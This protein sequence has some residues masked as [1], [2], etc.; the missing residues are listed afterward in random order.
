MP[1]SCFGL[2]CTWRVASSMALIESLRLEKTSKI[3]KSNRQPITTMPAKPCPEVPHPH[4]FSSLPHRFEDSPFTC[5]LRSWPPSHR[6]PPAQSH[7]PGR[8]ASR[9]RWEHP[10]RGERR[11]ELASCRLRRDGL[12]LRL[13]ARRT[14]RQSPDKAGPQEELPLGHQRSWARCHPALQT[15][16]EGTG[17]CLAV[18]LNGSGWFQALWL[19][20]PQ[21]SFPEIPWGYFEEEFFFWWRRSDQCV[22]FVQEV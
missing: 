7:L 8:A 11:G 20:K 2:C 15:A 22:W 1:L 14:S 16:W 12:P 19:V 18:W 17:A 5:K 9:S 10:G 3:I 4:V 6:A 21:K 13:A